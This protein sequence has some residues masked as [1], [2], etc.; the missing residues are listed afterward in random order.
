M[1]DSNLFLSPYKIFSDSSRKQIF[2][3]EIFWFY[4]EIVCCVYSLELPHWSNSNEYIQHTI[5]V[6][7]IKHTFISLKYR[8]LLPE[9]SPWLILSGFNYPYLEQ[10]SM[11]PK[12]FKPLTFE[13]TLHKFS[14]CRQTAKTL[15][16]D[17]Q[18]GFRLLC[19]TEKNEHFL[20]VTLKCI[21]EWTDDGVLRPFQHYLSHTKMMVG[22]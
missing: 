21:A 11:I 20:K 7:K 18:A 6:Q 5:T 16:T 13:Y 8:H 2:Y 1:A 4:H 12:M 3:K 9:L 15:R 19:I 22:W 10:I 14:G 17:M